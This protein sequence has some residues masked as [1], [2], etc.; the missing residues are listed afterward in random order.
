MEKTEINCDHP[1]LIFIEDATIIECIQCEL[2]WTCD[3]AYY[4]G[5]SQINNHKRTVGNK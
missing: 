1:E 5:N 4:E 3:N 2:Q